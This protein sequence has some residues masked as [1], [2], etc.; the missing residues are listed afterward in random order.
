MWLHGNAHRLP[1]IDIYTSRCMV[2][3]LTP[4]LIEVPGLFTTLT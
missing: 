2:E 3:Y 4:I 1:S